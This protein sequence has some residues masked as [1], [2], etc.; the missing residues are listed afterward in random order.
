MSPTPASAG[1]FEN[2]HTP[3]IACAREGDKLRVD[4]T[5]GHGVGHPNQPD[6]FIEWIELFVDDAPVGRFSFAAVAVD[7]AVTCVVNVDA[8]SKISALASCNL[9]GL[10]AYEVVAP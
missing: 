3:N 8:G 1:D 9:H 2:K 5:M 7:P 6:H 4:V 10:W